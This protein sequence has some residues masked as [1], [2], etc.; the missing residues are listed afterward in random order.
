MY[1]L[2]L[3]VIVKSVVSK[4]T[5]EELIT[6]RQNVSNVMKEE[7]I[8]KVQNHG[9]EVSEI[10]IIN[11]NFSDEFN[12]AIEAKQTTQQNA[13]KAEQDLERIKVESEQKIIEAEANELKN[14]E[15]TDATLKIK[16]IE[17][18]DGKLPAVSNGDDKIIDISSLV[19]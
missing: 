4:Y 7:L 16:W 2:E 12:A 17:K 3:F 11:F 9:I 18:W 14:K 6:N 8:N 19:K 10:N 1:Y 13:L 5:A 15:I